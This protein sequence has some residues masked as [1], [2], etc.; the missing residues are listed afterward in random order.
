[1]FKKLTYTI[2]FSFF[3]INLLFANDLLQKLQADISDGELDDYTNI[4]AAFIISGNKNYA[5]LKKSLKWYNEIIEDI[6]RKNL[7]KFDQIESAERLFMYNE[8]KKKAT[9][10]IDIFKKK[11]YN[12]VS[13]TVLYNLLCDDLG[14]STE[15][16]ETPTHVYTIF[17]NF[18]ETVMVE[19]TTSMGFNILKNL[20]R[21]SQYL[22]QYYPENMKLKIGLHRLYAYENSKGR[23]INNTELL[24]LICY[25]LA[26]FNSQDRN[27][28]KAY[29]YV[30]LAQCFNE[31]SRSNR[32]FEVSLYYRWGQQLF[33]D[34]EYYQAFEILA[35]A[36][37]RYP[38]NEDF[39]KNCLSAYVKALNQ[40]WNRKDWN[41][42]LTIMQEIADLEILSDKS[43]FFQK[44]IL[45]Q[46]INVLNS[47]NKKEDAESAIDFYNSNHN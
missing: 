16:F 37:Y 46:W 11:H 29:S 26:I 21:Y 17:N 44:R 38:D 22:A 35:D 6:N 1:M 41:L 30:E 40:L 15:A 18:A 25:N 5:E 34:R 45:K 4:E 14:L 20:N 23:K 8:Y 10:L 43:L 39:K 36:Y 13:A 33:G 27:Y 31:D 7:I 12:C 24:G 32:K 19:N 42:S 28:K 3:L 9:T 2:A 47:Q